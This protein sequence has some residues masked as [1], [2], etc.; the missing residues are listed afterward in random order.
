[1]DI[2][3]LQAKAMVRRLPI[4]A[5][6]ATG[7]WAGDRFCIFS[8]GPGKS[9]L[10][11]VKPEDTELSPA[12]PIVLPDLHGACN[13]PVLLTM[14]GAADRLYLAEAFGFKLDRR[15]A[16]PDTPRGGIYAINLSTGR[17]DQI[18]VGV[19]VNRMAVTPDGDGLYVLES[20]GRSPQRGVSLMRI[21]PAKRNGVF[22]SADRILEPGDWN[23]TLAHIPPALIPRGNLHAASS[24][25]R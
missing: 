18:A 6:P 16:C 4:P 15:R 13:E 21:D 17:V 9:Q 22:N 3:D 25:S 12:K 11:S 24:C 2:F 7:A 5:G 20:I 10:W 19:R 1:V 23:L 8:Y 14:V